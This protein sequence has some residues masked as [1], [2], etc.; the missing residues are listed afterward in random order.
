MKKS[1]LFSGF[2]SRTKMPCSRLSQT[3][4]WCCTSSV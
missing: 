3:P 1:E 4:F 2:G